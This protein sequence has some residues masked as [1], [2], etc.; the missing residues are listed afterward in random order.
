LRGEE[1]AL[2]NKKELKNASE[3]TSGF[4]KHCVESCLTVAWYL[5]PSL[6][7][8]ASVLNKQGRERGNIR[9]RTYSRPNL[10]IA[11]H[12][13]IQPWLNACSNALS[14]EKSFGLVCKGKVYGNVSRVGARG[15]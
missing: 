14:Y 10:A 5:L 11:W 1:A 9:P 3:V 13:P 15:T 2:V 4:P 8:L 7:G 6:A 12:T